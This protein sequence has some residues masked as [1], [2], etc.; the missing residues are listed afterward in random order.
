MNIQNLR[1]ILL[2]AYLTCAPFFVHADGLFISGNSAQDAFKDEGV[3]K[4][5]KAAID[6]NVPEA[7]KLIASGVN[8]NASGEGGVTPLIWTELGH[9]TEA[10]QVLLD[11]GA[12]PNKIILPGIDKPGFGPPAWMAAAAGQKDI[13]Q[14]LLNHGQIQI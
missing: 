8:V 10:M 12:D 13:L 4:L 9:D 14:I 6:H 5:I 11:L 3:V 2:G 1:N 7:R